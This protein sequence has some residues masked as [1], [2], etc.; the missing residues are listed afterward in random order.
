MK[1]KIVI[2][3]YFIISLLFIFFNKFFSE[4]F[5]L[6]IVLKSLIMPVLI[7][8]YIFNV[9]KKHKNAHVLMIIA[10][11][12]SFL[13]DLFMH[14]YEK[15]EIFFVLGL[16]SFLLTHVLYI[17]IFFK[18]PKN[19]SIFKNK[20][21][22]IPFVIF[23]GIF[24]TYLFKDLGEL[25]IP[26]IIYSTIITVMVAAALNRFKNVNSKS[27][28]LILIGALLFLFSDSCIAI[29]VF[30]IEFLFADEII[31][32]TYV[33]AQFLIVSGYLKQQKQENNL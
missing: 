13:G 10:L 30:K 9:D 22:L 31:M 12:F 32:I 33:I 3:L 19:Y 23:E 25:K 17:I 26:V 15:I 6:G 11:F 28:K 14:I 1:N 21:Y 16:S 20:F 29:N 27:F 2:S 4:Y 5:T 7:L 18:I 8:F 24:I